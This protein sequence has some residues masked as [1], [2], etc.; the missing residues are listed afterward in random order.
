MAATAVLYALHPAQ[1]AAVLQP[2]SWIVALSILFSLA[3]AGAMG[4]ND[5]RLGST[6][7]GL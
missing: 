2:L 1:G 3:L 6:R 4:A 7:L 5:V